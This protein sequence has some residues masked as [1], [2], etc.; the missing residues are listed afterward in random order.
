VELGLDPDET[1]QMWLGTLVHGIIDEVQR[2]ELPR[3]HDA[4]CRALD[5][6]WRPA[7]FPNRAVEHRRYLDARDMLWRWANHERPD[8]LRSEMWFEFPIDGAIIRGRID[9]VFPMENGHLRV[10]DYK[11][12]RYPI[13]ERETKTD[14]QLAAYYLAVKRTPELAALGPPGYLQLAYLGKGHQRDGF[15]RRG[16]SPATQPGY[17]D[18]VETRILELV[19]RIRGEEF[20]A[21]PEADCT[22]CSFKTICPRW[23][24]GAEVSL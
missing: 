3:D 2:G 24:E 1:Y 8:P 14:L 15:V 6:R 23:P 9:A 17:E 11:T 16:V 7:L 13:T 18:A 5:G 20:A 22:F 19:E 4:M 21:N 10:V 12:S